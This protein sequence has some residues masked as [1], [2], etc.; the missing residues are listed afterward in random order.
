MIHWSTD[1]PRQLTQTRNALHELWI[2]L[3]Y[4]SLVNWTEKI[5][6]KIT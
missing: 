4:I 3:S 2:Q 6:Y 1:V 5:I